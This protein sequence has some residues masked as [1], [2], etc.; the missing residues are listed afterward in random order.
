LIVFVPPLVL[1]VLFDRLLIHRAHRR[2][3]SILAPTGAAPNTSSA[4]L[5]TLGEDEEN[6]GNKFG[7]KPPLLFAVVGESVNN[8]LPDVFRTCNRKL[9]IS[10]ALKP[11]PVKP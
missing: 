3:K 6:H 10:P 8:W 5:E 11:E 4:I 7:P 9:T 2:A 1:N